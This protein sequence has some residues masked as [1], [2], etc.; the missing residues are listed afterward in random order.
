MRNIRGRQALREVLGLIRPM[1]RARYRV[2]AVRTFL[3]LLLLSLGSSAYTI[4]EIAKV[5]RLLMTMDL[6]LQISERVAQAKW[7]SGD[8]IEAPEREESV[9]ESFQALA[10]EVGVDPQV[11]RLFMRAQIEASKSRQRLMISRWKAERHPSFLQAPDLRIEIRPQLDQLARDLCLSLK[12]AQPVLRTEPAL[13]P[14]RMDV[15]WGARPDTA[16]LRAAEPLF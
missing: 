12:E 8:A 3:V 4:A 16:R 1:L 5:D 9:I 2:S 6:R 13:L 14:W 10:R 15:L 7:N 11:A